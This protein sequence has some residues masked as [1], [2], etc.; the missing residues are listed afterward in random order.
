MKKN[1]CKLVAQIEKSSSSARKESFKVTSKNANQ[2]VNKILVDSEAFNEPGITETYIKEEMSIFQ[3]ENSN[4][5]I[6][7][8]N[9][10]LKKRTEKPKGI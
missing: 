2:Y 1:L 6:V 7:N 4:Q 3:R 5:N 9:E 10:S 8:L